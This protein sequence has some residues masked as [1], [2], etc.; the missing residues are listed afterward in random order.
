MSAQPA[1]TL[2]TLSPLGVYQAKDDISY[3]NI[4]FRLTISSYQKTMTDAEVSVM[5]D[6]AAKLAHDQ[7]GAEKV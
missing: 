1:E 2:P 7:F 3:K 4:S 6:A 5:L